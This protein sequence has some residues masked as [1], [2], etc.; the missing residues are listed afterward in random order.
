MKSKLANFMCNTSV[1]NL[2]F[3]KMQF[4]R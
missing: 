4:K 2:Q 1:K 3:V